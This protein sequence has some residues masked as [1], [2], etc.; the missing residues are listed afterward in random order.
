MSQD[1]LAKKANVSV[2]SG[3]RLEASKVKHRRLVVDAA[4]ALVVWRH[5][6]NTSSLENQ[7][8]TQDFSGN[9]EAVDASRVWA[10]NA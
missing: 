6:P 4:D 5:G 7:L 10:G 2:V 9:E 3:R 8:Q 1:E